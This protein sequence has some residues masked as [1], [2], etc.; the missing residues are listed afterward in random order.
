[1]RYT[2]QDFH[3][4]FPDD[5]AC[6]AYIFRLR[7]PL[8]T[9]CRRCGR[10]DAFHPVGR[11]RA[12]ECACGAFF[13]PCAGTIFH[14]SPT[15]LTLWFH[16]LFL[17]ATAKNGVS[18]MELTRQLGVTYKCAWRMAQQIRLLMAQDADLLAG[19]LEADES[20]VGGKRHGKR[21]LGA[22]GKTPVFGVVE[23]GGRIRARVLC[24]ARSA[25]ILP[26][27][28]SLGVR[29][30]MLSTDESGIYNKAQ[31]IGYIHERVKHSAGQFVKG[32]VHTQTIDGFWSQFK[33]SVNGTYHQV[34]PKHL[35]TYLD[36]FCFRYSHRGDEAPLMETL[37]GRV[38]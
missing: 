18:V 35:Q 5:A 22:D 20:Y 38:A 1:M 9:K 6:L 25:I 36:E 24:K 33:R 2:I 31:A 14:K 34:S 7:C 12:Y 13:S 37:L 27:L 4:Q 10:E 19:V 29:G 21:G 28:A 15:P 8:G 26:L 11:W 16:A 23:R 17:F 3:R 30:S 32:A